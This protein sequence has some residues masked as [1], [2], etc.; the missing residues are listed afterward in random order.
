MAIRKTTTLLPEVFRTSKNEKFLNATLDQLVSEEDKIKVSGFIGR[1][2]AENFRKG[3]GYITESSSFRQNYQLEP[4]VVYE[5]AG[6]TIQSVGSIGDTLNTLRY[7]NATVTNQDTLFR[8][9]YYNWSSFVDY[10]KLINYGEYFWLPAGPDTVQVFGGTVDTTQT[11]SVLREE[12]GATNYRFDSS[13]GTP[14]PILYFARGGEYTFTVDQTGNPFWIQSELG[15]TGISASQIN[16]STREVP[17]ITNNGEDV[18]TITWRVPSSD[19][20][21]RFTNMATEYNVDLATD[22]P[23]KDLQNHK[24]HQ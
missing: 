8:Q 23:Y 14:N 16:V 17:G 3:D 7:N 1:K 20:Q 11:Y 4:G 18:G 22:L 2:N 12:T 9:D 5:D 13:T 15:T 21:S 19:S 6:G 24:Q 10:D